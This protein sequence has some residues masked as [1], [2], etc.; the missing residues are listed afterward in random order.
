MKNIYVVL[1]VLMALTA[2]GFGGSVIEDNSV[3]YADGFRA[4]KIA[5]LKEC[6]V[7]EYSSWNEGYEDGY[8]DGKLS[9][10]CDLMC[11][12]TMDTFEDEGETY[13]RIEPCLLEDY[14]EYME[15]CR[16]VGI[17]CRKTTCQ[18]TGI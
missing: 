10:I 4:G 17:V 8:K 16:A 14:N 7:P 5:S 11:Y 15:Q 3:F 9:C 1:I 13:I 18:T 12:D 6:P 2:G